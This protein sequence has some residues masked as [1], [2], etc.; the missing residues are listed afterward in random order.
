M[1]INPPVLSSQ[2]E[3]GEDQII[4]IKNPEENYTV[5]YQKVVLLMVKAREEGSTLMTLEVTRITVSRNKTMLAQE[6]VNHDSKTL[7]L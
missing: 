4:R 6:T 7:W 2:W 1:G 5:L 3:Y